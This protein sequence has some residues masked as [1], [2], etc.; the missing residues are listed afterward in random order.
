M[1]DAI[2]SIVTLWSK[3]LG[4]L[5]N[6]VFSWGNLQVSLLAVLFAV[7][8]TGLIISIFWRGART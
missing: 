4:T 7:L 8:G 1:A 5:N 6:C 2:Q 3:I